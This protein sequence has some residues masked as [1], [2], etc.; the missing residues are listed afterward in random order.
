M[1]KTTLLALLFASSLTVAQTLVDAPSA[2]RPAYLNTEVH[3]TTNYTPFKG[4]SRHPR[5]L[6]AFTGVVAFAV[7]ADVY[8]VTETEKGLKS[9]I[10]LEGNTWL[11][12]SDK[13]T[14]GQ[15]YRRDLLVVGL[16]ASPSVVAWIFRRP[17]FFYAGFAGPVALGI[18]HI[19][20][21]NAWKRLLEGQPA[22]G[23]E[24]VLPST[25]K[26]RFNIKND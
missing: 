26:R 14:T 23:G 5:L 4:E 21:G 7:A 8:D 25:T 13:P 16:S 12:P 9:G 24:Q 2:V 10:A 17:E 3:Q 11:L 19:G 18:H 1:K 6:W 20:G 15:L 22:T